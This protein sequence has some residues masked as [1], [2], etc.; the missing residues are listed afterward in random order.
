LSGTGQPE[1]VKG[2]FQLVVY[3]GAFFAEGGGLGAYY[4]NVTGF[5]I[6]FFFKCT[7][8]FAENPA[9]AAANNRAPEPF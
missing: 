3:I 9:Q 6:A 4:Y 2:N 7:K 1:L 5:E 8:S